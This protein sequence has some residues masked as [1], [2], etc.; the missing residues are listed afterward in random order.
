MAELVTSFSMP[1]LTSGA[2]FLFIILAFGGL[3]AALAGRAIA[4]SWRPWWHV[5]FYMLLLAVGV[6]F[7]QFSIFGSAF[8]SLHYYLV[9]A[10]LCLIVGLACFRARRVNQ[11]VT[12]YKWIN[13]RSGALS[14]RSRRPDKTG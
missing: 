3:A 12:C 8:L 7:I 14:W 9:D 5:V 10:T 11:M 4:A 2:I 13:E 1:K 6:R